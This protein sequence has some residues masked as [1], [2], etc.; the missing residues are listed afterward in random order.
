MS[1]A[2]FYTLDAN[3]IHKSEDGYWVRRADYDHLAKRLE[4][5]ERALQ[6]ECRKTNSVIKHLTAIT[7]MLAPE[8]IRLPDGR[9]MEFVPPGGQALEYWRG[10][11]QAIRDAKDH[12]RDAGA[13]NG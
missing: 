12:I 3:G 7:G 8:H 1:V 10:L 5:T 13:E 9:V 4:A 2:T 6:V 11:T